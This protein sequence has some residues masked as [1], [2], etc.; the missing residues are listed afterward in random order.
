[1]PPARTLRS[2]VE[3]GEREGGRG[4]ALDGELVDRAGEVDDG[5]IGALE[6]EAGEVALQIGE[7][8]GA[9]GRI[10]PD[11]VAFRGAEVPDRVV[12]VALV[13]DED[14]AFCAAIEILGRRRV[15]SAPA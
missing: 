2:E 13:E 7:G 4:D 5:V 9:E 3:H 1:M 15:V 11:L 6:R 14:V 12:A 10:E 8:R